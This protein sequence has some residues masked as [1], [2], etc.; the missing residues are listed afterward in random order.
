MKAEENVD[1]C[2][3]MGTLCD[4]VDL[5]GKRVNSMRSQVQDTNTIATVSINKRDGLQV[6]C[7]SQNP[8]VNIRPGCRLINPRSHLKGCSARIMAR[9]AASLT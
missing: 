6:G 4:D 8:R 9:C 3:R 5:S 7:T 2:Q 1:L